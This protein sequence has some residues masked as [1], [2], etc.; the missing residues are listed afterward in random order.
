MHF[1]KPQNER[2]ERAVL[3]AM[4]ALGIAY[5]GWPLCEPVTDA[6]ADDDADDADAEAL[7]FYE[8]VGGVD[9]QYT[10]SILCCDEDVMLIG[11]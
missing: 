10:V 8:R 4:R 5:A 6:D 11:L 2:C 3:D 7:A 1:E 9:S